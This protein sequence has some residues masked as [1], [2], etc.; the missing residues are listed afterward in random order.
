[1]YGIIQFTSRPI[2]LHSYSTFSI[3]KLK[4][5]LY[6]TLVF[7]LLISLEGNFKCPIWK[8]IHFS[9]LCTNGLQLH[10]LDNLGLH[11]LGLHTL[12]LYTLGLHTLGNLGLHTLG[13]HTLGNLGLHTLGLLL[14]LL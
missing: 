13:P 10:T 1:M 3:N 12:G 7:N 11:T 8:C 2:I 14:I 4:V 9:F 5:F 6:N